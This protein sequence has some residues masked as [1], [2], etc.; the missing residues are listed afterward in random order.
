MKRSNFHADA[1]RRKT[2]SISCRQL[3]ELLQHVSSLGMA[4]CIRISLYVRLPACTRLRISEALGLRRDRVDLNQGHC[5]RER[6]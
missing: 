6:K 3:E 5:D 2:P 1:V 4:G